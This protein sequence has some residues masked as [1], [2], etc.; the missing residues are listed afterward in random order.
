MD[1]M[2]ECEERLFVCITCIYIILD[3]LYMDDVVEDLG[4]ENPI[5]QL[6]E[7]AISSVPVCT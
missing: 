1:G 6:E 3:M 7:G 5:F 4:T 2:K